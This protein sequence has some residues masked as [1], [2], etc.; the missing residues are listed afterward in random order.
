MT[1]G[2]VDGVS[3]S[4]IAKV[5]GITK[6]AINKINGLSA[7]A[8]GEDFTTYTEVDAGGKLTVIS[9]K[10]TAANLLRNEDSYVYKDYTAGFFNALDIDFEVFISSVSDAGQGIAVMGLTV[11]IVNDTTA[12]GT[13][14][15]GVLFLA[16][17][18]IRLIRGNQVAF[19]SSITL[20]VN[21]LYYCTLARTA[22]SDTV[23]CTIYSDAGRTSVVDTLSISGYGTGTT[24]RYLYGLASFNTV[25][26][27]RFDGYIQNMIR[28]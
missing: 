6:A 22:S 5:L 7:V 12:W 25:E 23:T 18:T 19:D 17:T 4:A 9:S 20:T 26:A 2:K 10:I 24:Y 11:S 15:I 8:G 3:L 13:S 21:T 27:V 1:I 14:D 16:E 28:N